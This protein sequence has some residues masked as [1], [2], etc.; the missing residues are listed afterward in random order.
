MNR[1]VLASLLAVGLLAAPSFAFGQRTIDQ[2]PARTFPE[3][4]GTW[5]RD[6]LPA[7]AE[8]RAPLTRGFAADPL[9]CTTAPACRPVGG[10]DPAA[11]A[12]VTPPEPKLVIT[13]TAT[14]IM[15]AT[16]PRAP[17]GTDVFR[18]DGA[19]TNVGGGQGTLTLVAGGLLL[20]VK[21]ARMFGNS[22]SILTTTDLMSVSGD[23]LTI[24]RQYSRSLRPLDGDKVGHIVAT[25]EGGDTRVTCVYR[26]QAAP[27][28]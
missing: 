23:V 2:L 20:T 12:P 18:F 11:P 13:T 9:N 27:T 1:P 24:E 22:E 15:V 7:N 21:S 16:I 3:F 19:P 28:P 26:R 14:Q 6:D 4:A 10:F 8:P 17:H 5:V 25:N